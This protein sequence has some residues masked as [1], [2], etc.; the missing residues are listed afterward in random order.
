MVLSGTFKQPFPLKKKVKGFLRRYCKIS[1]AIQSKIQNM[2]KKGENKL[3]LVKALLPQTFSKRGTMQKNYLNFSVYP[4]PLPQDTYMHFH[5]VRDNLFLEHSH[6]CDGHNTNA[7]MRY[8]FK[9]TTLIQ[10][11]S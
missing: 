6:L 9:K 5:C 10:T 8:I 2:K 1:A 7:C 4:L 11:T 3:G